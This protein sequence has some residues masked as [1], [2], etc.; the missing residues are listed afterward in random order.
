[1]PSPLVPSEFH[2]PQK[3]LSVVQ[4]PYACRPGVAPTVISGA[5]HSGSASDAKLSVSARGGRDHPPYIRGP[6]HPHLRRARPSLA[7]LEYVLPGLLGPEAPPA[8]VVLLL[9]DLPRVG[10]REGLAYIFDRT[11]Q[12]RRRLAMDHAFSHYK[13][14]PIIPEHGRIQNDVPPSDRALRCPGGSGKGVCI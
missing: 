5:P 2:L 4:I 13:V 7:A 9:L 14:Y 1:M 6:L 3:P 12:E 10:R 8:L 11:R